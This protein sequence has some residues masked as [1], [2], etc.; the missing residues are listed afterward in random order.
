RDA[1]NRLREAHGGNTGNFDYRFRDTGLLGDPVSGGQNINSLQV[2]VGNLISELGSLRRQISDL[3]G[4]SLP[5]VSSIGRGSGTTRG[6]S[7]FTPV[8]TIGRLYI[9]NDAVELLFSKYFDYLPGG[10]FRLK[11]PLTVAEKA[12]A[13][14]MI[15]NLIESN[16][17]LDHLVGRDSKGRPFSDT[18]RA[19][20]LDIRGIHEE[21]ENLQRLL[22]T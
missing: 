11:R 10:E 7:H 2:D 22:E 19:M 6:V 12:E 20:D 3:T 4:R 17:G 9:R 14:R 15:G 5:A 1:F 16:T 18:N 8:G 21:L 13:R